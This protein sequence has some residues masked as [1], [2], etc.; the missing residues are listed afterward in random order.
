M[1]SKRREARTLAFQ[2]LFQV[3]AGGHTPGEAADN[4]LGDNNDHAVTSYVRETVS[5][6]HE[7]LPLL[8]KEITSLLDNWRLERLATVDLTILR[9]ALYE[10]DYRE[11]VPPVV[12]INEAVELAKKFGEADS[13]RFINGI[14]GACLKEKGGNR[15]RD[16]KGEPHA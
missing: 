1:K 9:L 4:V 11:D 16:R 6:V 7:K 5:G 14:L 12:A 15:E 3:E 8:D 10:I 13:G 2:A